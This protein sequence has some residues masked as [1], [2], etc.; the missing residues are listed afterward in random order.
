[1]K[2][3]IFLGSLLSIIVAGLPATTAA[4]GSTNYMDPPRI[5]IAGKFFANPSTVN[6]D[7]KHYTDEDKR[8]SPW[9]GP[10]GRHLWRMVDCKIRSVL[11]PDGSRQSKDPLVGTPVLSADEP[12]PPSSSISTST[13][14]GRPRSSVS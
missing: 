4:G 12:S 10:S 8:P 7:P 1:M 6:N 3:P 5:N 2:R 14:R 11:G 9:Q 13:S